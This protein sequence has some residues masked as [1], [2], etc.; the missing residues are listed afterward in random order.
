MIG[1][2]EPAEVARKRHPVF[3]LSRGISKIDKVFELWQFLERAIAMPFPEG[4][5]ATP[6]P[7]WSGL[8]MTM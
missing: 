5:L 4:T 3:L 7:G 2:L 8:A 1:G 6:A